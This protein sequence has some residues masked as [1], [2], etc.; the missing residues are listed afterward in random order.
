MP[1]RCLSY[2]GEKGEELWAKHMGYKKWCYWEHNEEHIGKLGNPLGT[3]WEDIGNRKKPKKYSFNLKYI[4]TIY[5][6]NYI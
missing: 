4:L 5:F 6:F 1:A 2:L 3:L